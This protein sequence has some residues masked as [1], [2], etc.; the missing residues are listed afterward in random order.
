ML[1]LIIF[2][3][4][5]A[6]KGTQAAL[7]AKKYKLT[8]LSSGDL[9]RQELNH[10]QL[11][12]QI[13]KYQLAGRLVPNKLIIAM[14]EKAA[15]ASLSGPGW[16]FDGY[17]RNLPQAQALDKFF[18]SRHIQLAG[19][20]NLQLS[21]REAIKRIMLRSQTSGRADDNRATLVNRF[22]VYRDQTAPLLDYYRRQNKVINVD[23]RPDIKTV[24][25]NIQKIIKR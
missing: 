25:K 3:P 8:H 9:L 18:S 2:G 4:P 14:I 5:G 13:H 24:L 20:L 7:L 23:G 6:G 22:R 16:I 19:V 10:G 1:N 12:A 17:P 11:G 15:A 21:E